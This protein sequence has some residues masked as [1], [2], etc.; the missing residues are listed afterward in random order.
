MNRP[1]IVLGHN[2]L[3]QSLSGHFSLTI[4]PA[5]LW[6]QGTCAVCDVGGLHQG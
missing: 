4:R 5:F 6:G 1:K 2:I 3:T